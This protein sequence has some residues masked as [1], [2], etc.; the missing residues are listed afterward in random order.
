MNTKCIFTMNN[1]HLVS[2]SLDW[3]SVNDVELGYENKKC[4]CFHYDNV[5]KWWNG[6]EENCFVSING[7]LVTN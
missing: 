2:F 6:N 7:Y 4:G 3:F 1:D 5:K